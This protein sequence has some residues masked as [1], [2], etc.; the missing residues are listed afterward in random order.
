MNLKTTVIALSCLLL[1][2]GCGG[3][4]PAAPAEPEPAAEMDVAHE[5]ALLD[6]WEDNIIAFGI[7][8]PNEAPPP[9]GGRGRG[10]RGRGGERPAPVYTVEGG[11]RLAQNPLYDFAFLSLEGRYDGDAVRAIAEGLRSP[12]AVSRKSLLVRIPSL[13][14]AGE[15]ATKERIK[16]I[17]D[18]GADGVTLPHV[19]N[20]EEARQ[21]AGFFEEL[22]ADVWS[23]ANPTGEVIAMVM[24]EDPE[25][26]EQ[27]SEIADMGGISVLACGIGSLTGAIAQ[28]RDPEAEGRVQSTEED[29]TTAEAMNMQVLEE[30]KRVG[31]ADMITANAENVE[32]RVQ[33]GFLAL[34]M[35]GA[36]AES[37]IEL[38]RA[39]AGRQ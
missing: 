38:G 16:E 22:G 32:R 20:L 11:E 19:R 4:P 14:N 29:R 6:L 12:T 31:I 17:L 3:A 25:A 23:P 36:D 28:A 5:N 35:S 8:V 13:E 9:P 33:E 1:A 10:G 34:I 37:T 15:E 30:T 21:I 26:I 7:S 18:A 27:V 2:A 39:A 24:L